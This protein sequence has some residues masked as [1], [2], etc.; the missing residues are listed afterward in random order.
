LTCCVAALAAGLLGVGPVGP[1]RATPVPPIADCGAESSWSV[2]DPSLAGLMGLLRPSLA[3][4][5][6]SFQGQLGRVEGFGAGDAYPQIWLRDSATLVPVTRWLYP[7]PE[8]ASWIEEHLAAQNGDGSLHDWIAAGDAASFREWAPQARNVF[9]G[10][11]VTLS[12][13][14][15]ST[16]ADQEASAVLAAWHVWRATGDDGWLTK[17]VL[18]QPLIAR[19]TRALLYVVLRRSDARLGLVVNALTADW[20][21]VAPVYPD[22]RAIYVD[23]RTP[24]AAGLYTNSMVTMAEQRLSEMLAASGD[25]AQAAS[26]RLRATALR[27]GVNRHLWQESRGFYR[28]HVITTPERAQGFPDDGDVF[29]LG[30]NA[31]AM[32]AGLADESRARRILATAETR[33]RDLGVST[34]AGALLPPYRAG[35]F[36]NPAVASQWSYQNGGQW[37]WF[38]GRLLLGLFE[39]GLSARARTHLDAIAR[40]AVADGGLFEWAT[41]EGRGKGSARY[42]G[43]AGALGDAV[44]SGLFGVDL[45]SDRLDI[46][47]RLGGERGSVALKQPSGGAC[48]AYVW[49]PPPPGDS[50]ATLTYRASAGG[51]GSLAVRLPEGRRLAS[52]TLD[53]SPVRLTERRVG[54]DRFAALQTDWAPHRLE[55]RLAPAR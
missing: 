13:D 31:V 3:A 9:V 5:H 27:D 52:A 48:V 19:L 16:E 39:A 30:G 33:R 23:A 40:R 46:T 37:D 22:Q 50:R 42:A 45:A 21:D 11:G 2:S 43:S 47:V 49:S 12:A 29:A 34:I 44:F 53:G 7:R 55:L 26:W 14:T 8:L 28:M 32:L 20:G 51:R 1:A 54:D 6:R 25:A 38:A 10:A 4:N 24:L 36:R 41:R 15:N 18:G 35:V 17:S